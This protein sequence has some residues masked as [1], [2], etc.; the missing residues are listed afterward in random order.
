MSKMIEKDLE[1]VRKC[2]AVSTDGIALSWH[3]SGALS[4]RLIRLI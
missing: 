3:F 1:N 4:R 2:S